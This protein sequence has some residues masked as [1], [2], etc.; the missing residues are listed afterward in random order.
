MNARTSFSA[1]RLAGCLLCVFALNAPMQASAQDIPP[2]SEEKEDIAARAFLNRCSGCH[3]VG[4]GAL[5]GPDLT[6]SIQWP[7]S[8]LAQATRRMQRNVGPLSEDEIQM[9]VAF[10]KSP[11][12]QPRLADERQK[13]ERQFAAQIDPG[14]AETGRRL[15]YGQATLKNGGMACHACHAASGAGGNMAVDLTR[16]HATMGDMPLIS[17]IQQ[18]GFNVMRA[19][20]R[21][22]PITRQ[23]AVHLAKFLERAGQQPPVAASPPPLHAIASGIALATFAAMAV[24]YRRRN[25]GVRARLV[26]RASGGQKP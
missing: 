5:S 23:E 18:S 4:G 6:T 1:F 11:D 12:V 24:G 22:C 13:F 17:A 15:F 8:D 14:S 20:Y 21:D 10:M 3:T 19:A 25:R 7:E 16:T 9:L 2:V 26:Q